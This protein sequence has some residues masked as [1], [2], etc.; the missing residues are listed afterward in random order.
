MTTLVTS[1]LEQFTEGSYASFA[2]ANYDYKLI[3]DVSKL[4]LKCE[5]LQVS[6]DLPVSP[7][8]LK[9]CILENS[10]NFYLYFSCNVLSFICMNLPLMRI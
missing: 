9:S 6:K 10:L 1:S 2:R 4:G 5:S 7:S 8:F 3:R